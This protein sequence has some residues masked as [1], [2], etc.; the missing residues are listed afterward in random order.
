MISILL[1]I[2]GT[3]GHT[4][5]FLIIKSTSGYYQ[6][7]HPYTHTNSTGISSR[8]SISVK[9]K[10][11]YGFILY[12]HV[13]PHPCFN[14]HVH[15]PSYAVEYVAHKYPPSYQEE[16]KYRHL[17]MYQHWGYVLIH[18]RIDVVIIFIWWKIKQ[19]IPSTWYVQVSNHVLLPWP[20]HNNITFMD[21]SLL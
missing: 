12:N 9:P 17:N 4:G 10:T 8:L 11:R 15:H 21:S 6:M 3:A 13:K 16:N 18:Q 5:T 20:H 19:T 7:D 1:L 14:N 2:W